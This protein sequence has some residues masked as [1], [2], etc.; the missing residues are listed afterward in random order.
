VFDGVFD[1]DKALED[2]ERPQRMLS[3]YDTGDHLHPNDNGYRAMAESMDLTLFMQENKA[4]SADQTAPVQAP[5]SKQESNDKGETTGEGR[6]P[7]SLP[8]TGLGG[9]ADGNGMT[10]ILLLIITAFMLAVS[11]LIFKLRFNRR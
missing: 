8:N 2:P 10:A 11:G 5:P 1:F 4:S 9:T 7:T 3:K 6:K